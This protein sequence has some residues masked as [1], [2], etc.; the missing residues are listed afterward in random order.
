LN[1]RPDFVKLLTKK[2]K[3]QRMISF[4]SASTIYLGYNSTGQCNVSKINK[5]VYIKL[6]ALQEEQNN[7]QNEQT[8]D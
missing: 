7:Q 4:I 3:P 5:W 2:I 6:N 1:V 8:T